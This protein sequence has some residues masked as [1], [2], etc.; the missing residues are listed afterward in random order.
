MASNAWRSRR[1]IQLSRAASS[2]RIDRPSLKRQSPPTVPRELIEQPVKDAR[3]YY[4]IVHNHNDETCHRI[5]AAHL[6]AL[7]PSS[8]TLID[9]KILPDEK[10]VTG[11]VEYMAGLSLPMLT[12]VN[13]LERCEGGAYCYIGRLDSMRV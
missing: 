9:D 12:M 7:S 1:S 5:L 2:S 11:S 3:A 4:Q 8:V 13:A 6:S 10:P